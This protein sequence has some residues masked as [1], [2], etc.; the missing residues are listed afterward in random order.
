MHRNI[1]RRFDG[2][3]FAIAQ[4]TFDDVAPARPAHGHTAVMNTRA[5]IDVH[6]GTEICRIDAAQPSDPVGAKTSKEPRVFYV[7]MN[8]STRVMPDDEIVRHMLGR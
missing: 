5:R 2:F 7:R 4:Q 8:N 3:Q 6:D 1:S